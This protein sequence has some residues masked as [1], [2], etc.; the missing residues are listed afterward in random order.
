MKS[1]DLRVKI[2]RQV[3]HVEKVM[4]LTNELVTKIFK[5]LKMFFFL[6]YFQLDENVRK[7]FYKK[8]RKMTLQSTVLKMF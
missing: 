8:A 3:G 7:F 1:Y 6:K 2:G 5:G 4:L